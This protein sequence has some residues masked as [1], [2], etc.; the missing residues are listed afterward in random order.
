[1]EKIFLI[2]V[3]LCLL[4]ILTFVMPAHADG[5]LTINATNMAP[6]YVNTN[7][8]YNMLKLVLNVTPESST[9]SVNITWI[10]ITL[11]GDAT[12]GNISAVELRNETDGVISKNMTWNT[13]Y[14]KTALRIPNGLYVNT[15]NR[16]VFVV[17]NTSFFAK[18][19]KTVGANINATFDI[20]TTESTNN[21]TITGDTISNHSQIQDIHATAFLSPRFVDTS[22]VNQ[23]YGYAITPKGE[24]KFTI[25]NITIPTGYSIT[26]ITEVRTTTTLLYN[27]TYTG[28][29]GFNLEFT[30][31]WIG[32]NYTTGFT[33]AGGKISI[34]FTVNTNSSTVNSTVFLS[35]IT[36]ANLSTVNTTVTTLG[37]INSTTKQLF[38]VQN[39][40]I[41][42]AA[43]IVNGTDY[44]EFNF[45][46]NFTAN[47]TTGGLIQFKMTDWNNSAGNIL[48]L[49]KTVG[50]YENTTFYSSLRLSTNASRIFNVTN[51]Y[52]FTDGI[53]LVPYQ[54]KAVSN[55]YYVVLKMIIPTST[56]I[57]SSWWATYN[58]LFRSF[59]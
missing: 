11:V 23:T 18:P 54:G 16:T 4:F 39:V 33:T 55:L 58:T 10:N 21:I 26:N 19:L 49:N 1:M 2:P 48:Y 42:K 31:N 43:A 53:S 34:N 6:A 17:F 45:T 51:E 56:P 14:N 46:L 35:N 50:T 27:K 38:T 8:S 59:A 22:V 3:I 13:T 57:S 12:T 40:K 9:S 20:N 30:T 36:G 37:G 47:V 29:A 25:I 24:D 41:I 52:N 44:W 28:P 15:S 5:N 32:I 7:Q